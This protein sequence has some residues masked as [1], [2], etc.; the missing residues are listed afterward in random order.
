MIKLSG[1]LAS[2]IFLALLAL[3]ANCL[4][5]VSDQNPP[6]EM[7]L[8]EDEL[9]KAAAAYEKVLSVAPDNLNTRLKYARFLRDNKFFEKAALEFRKT[10][11]QDPENL[12]LIKE[13]GKLLAD[14]KEYKEAII[15]YEKSKEVF[16]DDV[17]VDLLL[18]DSLLKSKQSDKAI[19]VYAAVFE[20]NPENKESLI[21]AGKIY[22][23]KNNYKEARE[24]FLKALKLDDKDGRVFAGLGRVELIRGK[25][26]NAIEIL[27]KAKEFSGID[28]DY[29]YFLAQAYLGNEEEEK[30]AQELEKLL[31]IAVDHNEARLLLARIYLDYGRYEEALK[32]LEKIQGENI[33]SKNLMLVFIYGATGDFENFWKKLKEK[34]LFAVFFLLII[35]A[36]SIGSV[37]VIGLLLASAYWA[38]RLTK[39]RASLF[40]YKRGALL[41]SFFVCLILF[42]LPGFLGIIL[43]SLIYNNWFLVFTCSYYITSK[44][45]QLALISQV[46]A[47]LMCSSFIF[48]LTLKK[49]SQTMPEFG[50]K[51]IR[52]GRFIRVSLAATILI[53]LCNLSYLYFYLRVNGHG[54]QV[55]F[56]SRVIAASGEMKETM[57]LFIFVVVAGPI[58]EEVIFRAFIFSYLRRYC[59]F[60]TA[61]F[62]SCILFGFFHFQGSLFV[63]IAVMGF[64]FAWLFERTRSILPPIAVHLTWNCFSFAAT[65][66]LVEYSEKVNINLLT[67]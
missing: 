58:A 27:Q 2:S 32:I 13:Y 53:F 48:W 59:N 28:N 54:P 42:F 31:K 52:I 62:I 49:N 65:F 50:F 57:W 38:G 10:I 44:A 56:I 17:E 67:S 18:A 4:A 47:L 22:L 46:A 45:V 34:P 51:K 30:A 41:Q 19:K 1:K 7:P 23:E 35:S 64:V 21:G 60:F 33:F 43:G 16:P 40:D 6:I 61:A 3:S 29:G 12:S 11:N 25:Y 9:A 24:Y 37:L 55:Q 5:N 20:K 36:V 14:L 39:G 15:L 8:P 26:A 66:F 63:P